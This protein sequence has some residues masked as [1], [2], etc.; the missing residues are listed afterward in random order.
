MN[1][2]LIPEPT[3][4][5]AEADYEAALAARYPALAEPV[6]A[7]RLLAALRV[8]ERELARLLSDPSTSRLV[9]ANALMQVRSA[10]R[11]GERGG[12]GVH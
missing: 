5:P 11:A 3:I 2:P 10:R 9:D 1:S 12:Q 4:P 8:A 7:A 6:V